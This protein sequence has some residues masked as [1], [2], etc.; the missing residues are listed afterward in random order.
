M[1]TGA[2][3]RKDFNDWIQSQTK[4]PSIDLCYGAYV[5]FFDQLGFYIDET[6]SFTGEDG[7]VEFKRSISTPKGN[8]YAGPYY[9]ARAKSREN[10]IEV[11][12]K[13]YEGK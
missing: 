11:I 1:L 6:V 5:Q 3:V 12:C 7:E 4:G 2:R 9:L 13:L 10:V 8:V